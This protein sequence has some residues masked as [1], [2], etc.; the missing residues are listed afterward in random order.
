MTSW[1]GRLARVGRHQGNNLWSVLRGR[2]PLSNPFTC[3]TLELDD[4]ELVRAWLAE[5]VHWGDD[6]IVRHFATSFAE[7]NGSRAACAFASGREAMTAAVEALA[8]PADAEVIV[9][10]YTCIA[11]PN[12]VRFAG[13][14]PVFA[15]IETGTYGL[16]VDAVRRALTPATK[17]IVVQHSYGLVCRDYEALLDLASRAKLAVIEDC[18]H[19]TGATWRGVRVGNRGDIGIY[20]TERSKVLCTMSG[21]IA[22]TNDPALAQRLQERWRA[23]ERC[24]DA[25]VLRLLNEAVVGYYRHKAPWRAVLGDLVE[26]AHAGAVP[27][28]FG[29]ALTKEETRGERPLRYGR[30]MAPAIAALGIN[31]LG[32]LDRFAVLRRAAAQRW[33]EVATSLGSPRPTVLDGSMPAMLRYPLLVSSEQKRDTSWVESRFGVVAGRWFETHLHPV[34]TEVT[35]CPGADLAVERCINLPTL[36]A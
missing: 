24:D 21:G 1:L 29:P 7:T 26:L 13:A 23:A 27:E 14:R 6:D 36:V 17:A 16:A 4:L 18:A 8:L 19:A 32:K 9:P 25:T 15:D 34:A 31:Q 33:N 20:S 10:G 35:G 5:R 2:R 12:A 22:T 11:V 3:M 30:R 28:L